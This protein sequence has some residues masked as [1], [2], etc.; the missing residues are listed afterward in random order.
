MKQETTIGEFKTTTR[1]EIEVISGKGKSVVAFRM[2][3][4]DPSSAEVSFGGDQW[5]SVVVADK[6]LSAFKDRF[7]IDME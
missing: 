5:V 3:P 7:P 2:S 6:A 4:D 1:I